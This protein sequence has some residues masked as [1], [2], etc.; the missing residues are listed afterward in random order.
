LKHDHLRP[1]RPRRTWLFS[2]VPFV[3]V[4]TAIVSIVGSAQ[5]AQPSSIYNA[6][7]TPN[8][9]G[10]GDTLTFTITKE[11]GPNSIGSVN[12]ALPTGFSV[13]GDSL[14]PITTDPAGKDWT[15]TLVDNVVELRAAASGSFPPLK[16]GQSLSLDMVAQCEPGSYLLDVAAKE[17]RSFTGGADI[18]GNDLNITCYDFVCPGGTTCD[19]TDGTTS[20]TTDVPAGAT[21]GINFKGAPTNFC[22]TEETGLARVQL[23]PLNYPPAQEYSVSFVVPGANG[24]SAV[25]K[26]NDGGITFEELFSCSSSNPAPCIASST[27]SPE[28]RVYVLTLLPVD[29]EIDW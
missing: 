13:D 9:V 2:L 8:P 23:D 4:V 15:A 6:T 16:N 10:T 3:L 24:S 14:G 28:G 18:T 27:G 26:S 11:S 19:V 21:L 1:D 17:S 29:P 7:L 25:C 5:A 22:G 20:L 12:I